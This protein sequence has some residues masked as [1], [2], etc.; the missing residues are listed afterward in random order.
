MDCSKS[1]FTI[2]SCCTLIESKIKFQ[3]TRILY[4]FS[5]KPLPRLLNWLWSWSDSWK[6][7]DES[8][9]VWKS[10]KSWFDSVQ[11]CEFACSA[12]FIE[13]TF[14]LKRSEICFAGS[15][16]LYFPSSALTNEADVRGTEKPF[17]EHFC[18]K[19]PA[20]K[21]AWNAMLRSWIR[22]PNN[23]QRFWT[24]ELWSLLFHESDQQ[25]SQ[26]MSGFREKLF[27]IK[28]SWKLI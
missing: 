15:R 24:N 8:S 28:V 5:R 6:S 11:I 12:T 13:G 3:E 26:F 20:I 1:F 7:N 2:W 23:F 18:R 25:Q 22:S 9:I 19:G 10:W 17:S 16:T 21:V 14:P 27:R 4:N